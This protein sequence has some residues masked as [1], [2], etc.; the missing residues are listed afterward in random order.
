MFLRYA[1]DYLCGFLW[2]NMSLRVIRNAR[3]TWSQTSSCPA[4]VARI[5]QV[6]YVRIW[7]S[8]GRQQAHL[9]AFRPT[10]GH[11]WGPEFRHDT[12]LI[13]LLHLDLRMIFKGK[14]KVFKCQ[15]Q[16]TRE[17]QIRHQTDMLSHAV[18]LN[19]PFVQ[20]ILNYPVR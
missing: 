12:D 20:Q 2:G 16:N 10:T 1:A 19:A 11:L 14:A 13:P 3:L 4:T 7:I 15:Y 9:V 18:E 5:G 8:L 17:P 6:L